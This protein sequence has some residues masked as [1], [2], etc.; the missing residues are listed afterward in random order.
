MPGRYDYGRAAPALA[1]AKTVGR[2]V[3]YDKY[4][5]AQ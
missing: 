4:M 3:F 5:L 2:S 1:S